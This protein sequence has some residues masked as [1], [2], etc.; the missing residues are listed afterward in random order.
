MALN[1]TIDELYTKI[2]E[3]V[4]LCIEQDAKVINMISA[5]VIRTYLQ[6]LY[7]TENALRK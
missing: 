3:I 5:D 2:K 7:L 1:E 4:I 6:D